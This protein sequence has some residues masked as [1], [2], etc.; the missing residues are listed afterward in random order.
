MTWRSRRA[1]T[2][3]PRW[4]S[5]ELYPGAR[6]AARSAD[7]HFEPSG[8]VVGHLPEFQFNGE[9][10]LLDQLVADGVVDRLQLVGQPA[11]VHPIEDLLGGDQAAGDQVD[12][13]AGDVG[14]K[15]RQL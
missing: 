1:A 6:I 9:D 5:S 12:G 8:R 4:P 3:R 15:R 7:P 10:P 14:G 11:G 2:G 13:L